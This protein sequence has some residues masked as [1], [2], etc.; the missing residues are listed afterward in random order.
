VEIDTTDL[1]ANLVETDV[2]ETLKTR[3][4]DCSDTM[5]RDKKVFFPSHE[6]AFSARHITRN[7]APL[8]SLLLVRTEGRKFGPVRQINLVI[9]TPQ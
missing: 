5:V 2:V 8:T 1:A 9:C 6:D 4:R 3:T 7:V